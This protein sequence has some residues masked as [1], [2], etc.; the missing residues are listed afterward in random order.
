MGTL[1]APMSQDSTW[2]CLELAESSPLLVDG[3]VLR[4]LNIATGCE[5]RQAGNANCPDL[6]FISSMHSAQAIVLRQQVSAE[7]AGFVHSAFNPEGD[8]TFWNIVPSKPKLQRFRTDVRRSF[9]PRGWRNEGQMLEKCKG[10]GIE[11][12]GS[13]YGRN[14]TPGLLLICHAAHLSRASSQKTGDLQNMI[15]GQYRKLTN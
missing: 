4:N 14:W 15:Y 3:V 5:C 9:R 12:A 11:R 6:P 10:G 1:P 13:Y 7:T 8:M 2:G